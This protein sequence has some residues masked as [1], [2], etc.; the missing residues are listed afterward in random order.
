MFGLPPTT[1]TPAILYSLGFLHTEVRIKKNQLLYLQKLLNK[2]EGHWAKD[3]L[4]ILQEGNIGWAKNI[5]QILEEWDLNME[6]EQIARL[7]KVEWKRMVE[8]ASEKTHKNKLT[9]DCYKSEGGLRR[10]KTKT[11]TIAERIEDGYERK[12]LNIIQS[13]SVLE[14]RALIMG[15]YGML[16]CAANFTM[17]YNGKDCK[18]CGTLDDENHRVN[19]CILYRMINLYDSDE[20]CNF[21][22]I[23]SVNQDRIREVLAIVLKIW[24]LQYGK[25]TVRNC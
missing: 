11:R 2:P 21:R 18:H 6:W 4:M 12:P 23:Y 24:D 22:E 1:P 3:M 16:D 9:K 5:T 14:T 25:N 13:L 7:S 10:A 8:E 17:K 20:K 19:D 15:R